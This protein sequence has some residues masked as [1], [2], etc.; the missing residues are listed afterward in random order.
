MSWVEQWTR[1]SD[2]ARR[3]MSTV[4]EFG[5]AWEGA[6]MRDVRIEGTGPPATQRRPP[7][8]SETRVNTGLFVLLGLVAVLAWR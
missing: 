6:T 7:T 5:S 4:D 8:T 2:G 3:A 1:I